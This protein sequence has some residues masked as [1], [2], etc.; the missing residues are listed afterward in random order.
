MAVVSWCPGVGS[1]TGLAVESEASNAISDDVAAGTEAG[2]V[3]MVTAPMARAAKIITV[4]PS[5]LLVNIETH[6]FH[7]LL[8]T[9]A[10]P[11]R[12]GLAVAYWYD[13]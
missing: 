3:A 12:R 2:V 4:N 7:G 6:P 10:R 11:T 5:R 1:V 8:V 9:R 13:T